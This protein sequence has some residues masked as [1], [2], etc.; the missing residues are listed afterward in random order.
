MDYG[1]NG[2]CVHQNMGKE[3]FGER[4][5]RQRWKWW[6]MG[7]GEMNFNPLTTLEKALKGKG[8]RGRGG[9]DGFWDTD[10]IHNIRHGRHRF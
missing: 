8:V 6:N 7:T 1:K 4:G 2:L 3:G 9:R 5:M 10:V